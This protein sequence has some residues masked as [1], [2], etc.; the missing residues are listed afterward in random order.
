[1]SAGA[2]MRPRGLDVLHEAGLTQ[3]QHPCGSLHSKQRYGL[4]IDFLA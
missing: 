3:K 2:H 1:M 4:V